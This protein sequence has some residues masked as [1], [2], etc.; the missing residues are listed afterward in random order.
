MLQC[1][2]LEITCPKCQL[3]FNRGEIN[4]RHTNVVC[5]KEQLRQVRQ[6]SEE[7][8]RNFEKQSEEYNYELQKLRQI[9]DE[10]AKQIKKIEDY[11]CK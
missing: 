5:L 6:V 8:K 3:V 7:N 1:T 2:S 11:L 10:Y 4:E 9:N